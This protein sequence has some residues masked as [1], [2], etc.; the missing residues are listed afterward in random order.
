MEILFF[1]IHSFV[2]LSIILPYTT[3]RY[4]NVSVSISVMEKIQVGVDDEA[5]KVLVDYKK[6]H[7]LKSLDVAM[8][9]LLLEYKKYTGEE[10]KRKSKKEQEE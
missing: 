5:K 6:K 10:S 3:A 7:G 9:N 2:K 8:N 4:I 1:V